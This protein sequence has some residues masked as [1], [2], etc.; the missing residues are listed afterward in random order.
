MFDPTPAG[1]GEEL[2]R[3]GS[4]WRARLGRI[5][6]TLRFQ[7]S[8]WV[9]EYDLASQLELFRTIGR[10]IKNVAVKVKEAALRVKY[11]VVAYWYFSFAIGLGIA[12]LLL[13]RMRRRPNDFVTARASPRR[14][15]STVAEVYLAVAK[16]LAKSGFTRES[17]ITP[18]ELATRMTERG[19]PGAAEVTELVELYYAA[20]WGSQRDP[21]A[22]DRAQK[23]AMKI[24]T[25]L[26]A[27]RRAA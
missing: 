22:E 14:T 12:Y 15:R 24:K 1:S 2:G 3:G 4:G 27:K 25:A 20:E 7:W 21:A 26:D 16:Q 17:G 6:D 10:G 18:R 8:K 23:L 13:R 9:I 19:D 11:A 5:V